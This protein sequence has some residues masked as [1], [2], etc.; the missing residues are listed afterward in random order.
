MHTRY[1][2]LL[3]GLVRIHPSVTRRAVS[4][5]AYELTDLKFDAIQTLQYTMGRTVSPNQLVRPLAEA[6]GISTEATTLAVDMTRVAARS[7][8]MTDRLPKAIAAG[9]LYTA[10]LAV[11]SGRNGSLR[12]EQSFGSSGASRH[13]RSRGPKSSPSMKRNA[14]IG[15]H[16]T[17]RGSTEMS[18][19]EFA[20]I[21]PPSLRKYSREVAEIYLDTGAENASP[22]ARQRMA[23]L[24]LQ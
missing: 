18:I 14:Q 6:A 21:T 16:R 15:H 5:A 19:C 22:R 13:P 3:G 23:R 10:S 2:R 17:D 7:P 4:E 9:C 1:P 8:K 20:S 11:G 24:R 12:F